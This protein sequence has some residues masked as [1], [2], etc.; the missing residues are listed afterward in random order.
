MNKSC[1]TVCSSVSD[2]RRTVY[3]SFP[4]EILVDKNG[5]RLH[6]VGRLDADTEGLLLLTNDGDLSN[7][8]TRPENKIKKTYLA[9]LKN[10]VSEDE[11]KIYSEK[12]MAGI[13]L[14]PEKKF[15]WQKSGPAFLAW[16][17][18][19]ECEITLTEGKFHEVKRIFRALG[20]EVE[21]LRR[22]SFAEISLPEDLKNGEWRSLTEDELEKLA[23][24]A[25]LERQ[26]MKP[27]SSE[28]S[29][30]RAEE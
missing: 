12:A 29:R 23:L 27:R 2:R 5:A 15:G 9:A 20:N 28:A 8:L 14:P 22:I 13:F 3:E 11:Q 18:G 24:L 10:S 26:A 1:G 16:I 30:R 6:T 25:P 17:S 21:K 7:F 4:P 19:N